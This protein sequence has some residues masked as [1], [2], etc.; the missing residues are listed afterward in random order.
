MMV[1]LL[2]MKS[3][4]KTSPAFSVIETVI[5][6]AITC[7]MVSLGSLNL[8]EYQ[9]QLIFE[10]TVREI[11][12]AFEQATRVSILT[13]R[14]TDITYFAESSTITFTGNKYRRRLTIDSEIKVS[15]LDNFSISGEGTVNPRTLT[16]SDGKRK[17]RLKVQMTWGRSVNEN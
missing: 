3:H 1:R 6:L 2:I 16:F 4:R 17:E 8:R 12:A 7:A 15:G 11:R 14:A 5:V 9:R 13:K 10:N